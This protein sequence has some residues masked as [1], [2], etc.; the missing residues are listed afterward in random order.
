[1]RAGA[2]G[3]VVQADV[4]QNAYSPYRWRRDAD[5]KALQEADT[6]WKAFLLGRP[7]RPFD[8]RQYLEFRLFHDFSTGI[9]DQWMTHMIDTVHM[10][11]GARFPRSVVAHGGTYAW[12]DHRENGD[13]VHVTLE[14]PG[15]LCSYACSLA[16][17][18][19]STCRVAG[20]KGML[21]YENDWRLT[22]GDG[23]GAKAEVKPVEPKEG[24]K[25]TMDQIHMRNWLEC[26]HQGRRQ[27]HCTAEHGYQHA[28]A[29]ILADQALH[30]GRRMVFDEAKRVIREA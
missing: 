5:V 18:H 22:V 1:M 3:R 2:V 17:A 26:V 12:K 7:E 6:D 23:K 24:L 16:T 30:R 19:G 8:P 11:T 4:M 27:T 9:I 13:T 25:G 21:E 14:Y 15:F 10:L 29:C 20:Q 28:V